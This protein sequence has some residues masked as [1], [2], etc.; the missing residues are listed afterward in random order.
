M[1]RAKI[2]PD[3]PVNAEQSLPTPK[4]HQSTPNAA[5]KFDVKREWMSKDYISESNPSRP[6]SRGDGRLAEAKSEY[7]LEGERKREKVEIS[8]ES[9]SDS[10]SD[11]IE[12]YPKVDVEEYP[13]N[14]PNALKSDGKEPSRGS[15][16]KYNV[17]FAPNPKDR[18]RLR[19]SSMMGKTPFHPWTVQSAPR[20]EDSTEEVKE[21]A[22]R[23]SLEPPLHRK[24]SVTS[25]QQ[26]RRRV[27]D[28]E[29]REI[30]T[31]KQM[32]IRERLSPSGSAG[33]ADRYS[34][35]LIHPNRSQTPLSPFSDASRRRFHP[36]NT[37]VRGAVREVHQTL[38][39]EAKAEKE[40]E[41]TTNLTVTSPVLSRISSERDVFV[42]INWNFFN[43]F[44]I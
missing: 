5:P 28:K 43:K 32:P 7:P 2:S 4:V 24:A 30:T 17:S 6:V 14:D 42:D 9:G 15:L 11:D 12:E 16:L 13:K 44:Q 23:G 41:S 27:N 1:F 36:K 33:S 25:Q 37:F 21:L 18:S 20:S 34:D 35:D 8:T 40:S 19:S 10:S 39:V 3:T 26:R 22:E 31:P 29:D 38:I